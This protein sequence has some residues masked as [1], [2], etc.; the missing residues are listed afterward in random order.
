MDE[1]LPKGQFQN[2]I[3]E[4]KWFIGC[5]F[6]TGFIECSQFAS[7]EVSEIDLAYFSLFNFSTIRKNNAFLYSE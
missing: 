6:G 7:G 1:S 4:N 3:G 2:W 5:F